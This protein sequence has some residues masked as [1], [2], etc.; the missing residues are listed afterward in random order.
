MTNPYEDPHPNYFF[1][2]T[3]FIEVLVEL[4]PAHQQETLTRHQ[5]VR[6]G[7]EEVGKHQNVEVVPDAGTAVRDD[8]DEEKDL[9]DG[10]SDEAV[11]EGGLHVWLTEDDNGG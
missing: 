11:V 7:V 8:E 6:Q 2:T 10:E 1:H 3:T 9:E 4:E 5:D